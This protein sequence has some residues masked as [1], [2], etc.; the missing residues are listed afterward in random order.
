MRKLFT[1]VFVC[2]AA[3]SAMA[4]EVTYAEPTVVTPSGVA[5][6]SNSA[7]SFE[8][9]NITVECTTGAVSENYFSCYA[10]KSITFTATQNIR[11]VVVNGYVKKG[12]EAEVNNGEVNYVDA[13]E[14]E[15]EDDPV[16]VIYDVNAPSVTIDCVKQM[17][18]YSV[19][20]YF[21]TDPDVTIGGDDDDEEE[22]NYSYEPTEKT[23]LDIT[24]DEMLYTDYSEDAGFPILD[25]YF[26]SDD[27]EMDLYVYTSLAE[28]TVLA[29]GTYPITSTYE[30]G[31]VLASP[32]GNDEEDYP[33]FIAADFEYYEFYDAWGYNS[34]YY[35]VDGT[36]TVTEDAAGVKMTLEA[37]T[38]NGS[39]VNATYLGAPIDYEVYVGLDSVKTTA[40]AGVRKL[41][42][43]GRILIQKGNDLYTTQGIKVL[44]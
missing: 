24:F 16:L 8:Q 30:E 40:D 41:L 11:A 13:S 38:Y 43:D 17:R 35:L 10:G 18:C 42:K 3:I 21:T 25:L 44:K 22:L 34:A 4:D 29:P 9:N 14:G 23:T 2:C 15:V 31:T 28:G 27:Y 6:A 37:T 32:G 26:V 36:L 20:F 19:E 7:Y 39:T 33:S 5:A 12:F 1:L